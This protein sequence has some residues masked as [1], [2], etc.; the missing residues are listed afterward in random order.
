MYTKIQVSYG[1]VLFADLRNF[2][3]LRKQDIT[4]GSNKIVYTY[5]VVG[6]YNSKEY[7]I[8]EDIYDKLKVKMSGN[9][10]VVCTCGDGDGCNLCKGD[11]IVPIK[12]VG[13]PSKDV[14][15]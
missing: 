9:Y 7:D 14:K 13:R 11:N 6:V 3:L 4:E 12:K 15:S 10:E 5:F 8:E 1:P 2:Y